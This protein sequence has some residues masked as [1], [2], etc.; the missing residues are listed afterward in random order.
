MRK[1]SHSRPF[2]SDRLPTDFQAYQESCD[3]VGRFLCPDGRADCPIKSKAD[4]IAITLGFI[5]AF[6]AIANLVS[7]HH[8]DGNRFKETHTTY[9]DQVEVR[10]GKCHAPIHKKENRK[11]KE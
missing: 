8:V 6:R 4:P 10:C 5:Q 11:I 9:P 2:Q 3:E 1:E 7:L